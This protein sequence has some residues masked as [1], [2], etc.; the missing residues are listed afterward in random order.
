MREGMPSEGSDM[1]NNE[2]SVWQL[3]AQKRFP[4]SV[5]GIRG[6]GKWAVVSKCHRRWSV[7]LYP[8]AARRDAKYDAWFE[9]GCGPDCQD[10]HFKFDLSL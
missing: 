10:S 4:Y 2:L 8:D 7:L 6:D 9:N 3:A 1:E 5:Q